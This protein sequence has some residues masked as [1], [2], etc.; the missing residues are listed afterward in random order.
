MCAMK[1]IP[2]FFCAGILFAPLLSQPVE[3][4]TVTLKVNQKKKDV[5]LDWLLD[6]ENLWAM[7]PDDLEKKA[8]KRHFVWQDKERTRAR[9]NPDK[10]QYTLK[11]KNIGEVL[12]NF[13]AG[14]L[15]SAAISV[16]NKGD[17][18]SIIKQGPF[19][20]ATATVRSLLGAAS[21][22]KEELRKKN[23]MITKAEG[24]VWRCKKALYI[25]E[26]LFLPEKV[27]DYM[28]I[29][30]HGEFVRIR[31][32]PP[33]AQL[34]VQLT[35]QKVTVTRPTLAARVKRE[36]KKAVLED[37]PMVDQGSKGYC[38]V[39][40][41]ERV[42]RYYG[43]DV[44]MHDLANLAETYGGT[45]PDKMKSAVFKVS[46]KL[47]MRTRESFFLKNKQFEV[48]L[49]DYNR[50][51]KRE[52]KGEIDLKG[53]VSWGDIDPSV[54]KLSRTASPDYNKFKQ[55]VVQN[56][57][58]GIP[59][60]WALQLGLFW[61]DKIEESW[62]ANRYATTKDGNEEDKDDKEAK[63]D[64][65]ERAK[66]MEELRKKNPR[67]PSYMGGGHMRLIVGYDAEKQL[68]FYTD[69][70]GPGHELK[71]MPI[72]EAWTTTLAMFV[73]EPQ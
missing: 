46:Q 44:D 71:S 68:I 63:E 66:E 22:A 24:A 10:F 52:K 70:W 43:A 2:L 4:Q 3:A 27:E 45:D 37:L 17:E 58:K 16:L 12:I 11:E 49:K 55:E 28:R 14:K 31:I 5:A 13:T 21:G 30:A 56:I 29:V 59:I 9:F 48:L 54:L 34:G 1:A 32:M 64:A 62:E 6:E 20:E 72:D 19:N 26:W 69:S 40:S 39:A 51:A 50:I 35:K 61:E 33:Q 8:G 57:N 7:T 67:P 73:I 36:G 38:A 18:N 53:R 65:E 42:L 60:M 47:S 41:F 15:S 25:G 23:E